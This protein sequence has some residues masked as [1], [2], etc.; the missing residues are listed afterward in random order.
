M[1]PSPAKPTTTTTTTPGSTPVVRYLTQ[2]DPTTGETKQ[3][4]V[5]QKYAGLLE[6]WIKDGKDINTIPTVN[7]AEMTVWQTNRRKQVKN[8]IQKESVAMA[9]REEKAKDEM[10]RAQREAALEAGE[11]PPPDPKNPEQPDSGGDDGGGGE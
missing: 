1:A 3:R 5:E 11:T 9:K 2:V 7:D 6:Q 10:L 8:D 4:P